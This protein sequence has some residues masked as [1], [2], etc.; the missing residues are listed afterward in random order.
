MLNQLHIANTI[1]TSATEE[2]FQFL[3]WIVR[4]NS[5]LIHYANLALNRIIHLLRMNKKVMD[6][7]CFYQRQKVNVQISV[8]EI[9]VNKNKVEF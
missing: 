6:F 2:N 4:S 9:A 1:P 7:Q 3:L 8:K 5:E